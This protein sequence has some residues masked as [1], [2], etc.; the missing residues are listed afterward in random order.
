MNINLNQAQWINQPQHFTVSRESITIATEPN[1]DFWQRTYYGFQND[2]APA[3]LLTSDLNFSFTTRVSFN[4]QARFDQA[5]VIIYMDR[6]NWFKASVEFENTK[7]SR[8]G[9]V[10]TNHGYSD[11]ATTDISTISSIWY[12]LSRRGADFLIEHSLNGEDFKQMRIFHLAVLGDTEAN[13]KL[14]PQEIHA[15]PVRFG[16]YACSPLDSSFTATFEE[17]SLTNS[18]WMAH[19]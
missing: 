19:E 14:T 7:M 17:L 11:W 9:S 15:Q 16:I 12:R 13:G 4:Y 8:L 3:I 18:L 6:D 5:G 2:N 1:T 10:V